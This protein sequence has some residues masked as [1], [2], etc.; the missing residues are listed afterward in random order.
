MNLPKTMKA[1]VLFGYKNL[2]LQE[3]PVEEPKAGEVLI[4]VGACGI[5][6]SDIRYYYGENAWSL[7]TLGYN[8]PTPGAAILGHEVAGTIVKLGTNTSEWQVGDRVGV[9]AF[10]SCGRCEFCLQN[11]PNLCAFQHHIGHDG[12]WKEV[13]YAP[14][15]Y[16][17]Y[18]PIWQDKIFSLPEHISFVEATQLDGLAVA[19]HAINRS[20]LT[21]GESLVVVG[22][23]AIGLLIAQVGI[24][25]GAGKVMVLD[26][27]EKPLNI[28]NQLGIREARRI[29]HD[30]L[31]KEIQD[32]TNQKGADVIIDTVGTGKTITESL[33]SL[34]RFGRLVL[35][36]TTEDEITI[37]PT[38]LA[39]ER[40]ITTSANNLYRNYPQA[41]SLLAS[42][43]VQ[44]KPFIT[45]VFPLES[46][47]EAFQLALDKENNDVIK[48]VLVP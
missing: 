2:T 8:E 33:R 44:T 38:D 28:A 15:G 13:D 40:I 35:V 20:R 6:G 26:T 11:L 45:H 3:V 32:F 36:A 19:I 16:S 41:I 39:G 12:R 27:R 7:H 37:K 4:K 10:K 23:G 21:I 5:C 43:K 46:L 47:G 1:G 9:L 18:L 22:S 29:N 17:E 31:K 25:L 24:T 14:G 48:I 34:N 42:G 30:N